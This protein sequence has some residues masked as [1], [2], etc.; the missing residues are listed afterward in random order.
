MKKKHL[1]QSCL[2][3]VL[4][5][6]MLG[7]LFAKLN[8]GENIPLTY[9]LEPKS[10]D[11]ISVRFDSEIVAEMTLTNKSS[12]QP[13][14]WKLFKGNEPRGTMVLSGEVKPS[15]Q[16]WNP[17]FNINLGDG[18]YTFLFYNDDGSALRGILSLK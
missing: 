7:F 4:V 12:S 2:I 16:F 5:I 15:E 17:S 18:V 3:F 8:Q 10:S 14:I 6:I 1:L 11:K 9:N 13:I